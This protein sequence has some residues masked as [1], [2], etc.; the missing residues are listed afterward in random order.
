MCVISS[1]F[2]KKPIMGYFKTLYLSGVLYDLKSV[3]ISFA[4]AVQMTNLVTSSCQTPLTWS[5]SYDDGCSESDYP[6]VCFYSIC[7]SAITAC[8]N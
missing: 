1:Q 3:K 5:L 7:F 2:I 6:A 8:G 4:Q